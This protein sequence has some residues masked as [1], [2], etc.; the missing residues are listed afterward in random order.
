MNKQR[1][2]VGRYY[3]TKVGGRDSRSCM[4]WLLQVTYDVGVPTRG[5]MKQMMQ[6]ES[7]VVGLLHD[8]TIGWNEYREGTQMA[9]KFWR[10]HRKKSTQRLWWEIGEGW[11]IGFGEAIVKWST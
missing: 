4:K 8:E 5:Y 9:Y 3:E 1:R 10:D 2:D 6:V 7:W 11:D